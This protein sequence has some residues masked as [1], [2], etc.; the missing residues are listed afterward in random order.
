MCCLAA[1]RKGGGGERENTTRLPP[2][3]C[4]HTDKLLSVNDLGRRVDGWIKHRARTP[5]PSVTASLALIEDSKQRRAEIHVF[6]PQTLS[7]E[8]ASGFNE[9]LEAWW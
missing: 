9:E 6:T 5:P 3:S 1:K 8:R 2:S 7:D 4:S